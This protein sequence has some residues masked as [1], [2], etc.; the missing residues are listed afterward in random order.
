MGTNQ[1]KVVR[2][3]V[4]VEDFSKLNWCKYML[5]CLGSRKK[6]WKRD[7]KSSYYSGPITLLIVSLKYFY[8]NVYIS[9]RFIIDVLIK[10]MFFFSV[11]VRV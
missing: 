4:L 11:G 2:K 8:M 5:D 1:I 7:D 6:L 10:L 9:Y 3:L